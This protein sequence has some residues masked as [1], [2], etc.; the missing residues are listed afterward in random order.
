MTPSTKCSC[1]RSPPKLANGKTTIERRGGADF[2][3]ASFC[4]L[5]D[6][7]PDELIAATGH[8][9]DP[10]LAAGGCAEHPAQRRDL[11]REVAF[12]DRL[13]GPSGF[14][15]R[16]LRKQC[17]GLF[18]QRPQQGDRPPA[19]RYGLFSA[20]QQPIPECPVEMGRAHRSSCLVHNRFGDFSELFR[21]GFRTFVR[22]SRKIC[23]LSATART[24]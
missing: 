2:S 15:Q 17:A 20:Q 23:A 14:D 21:I 1:S 5:R 24:A 12:L 19:K 16:V 4:S 22:A 3:G 9:L 6:D 10:T 18:N 8:G 7:R 13:A 11:N